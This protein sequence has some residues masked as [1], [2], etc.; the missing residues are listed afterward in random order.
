MEHETFGRIVAAL[1][2]EQIN[3]SNGHSWSQQDL[4]DETGLTQRIVSK[5]ERGRQARLDGG[6]LR[7]LARAFNLTSLERR[8]FFAMASEVAD[9]EIVRTDLCNEEVFAQVWALLDALCAPAFL[10]DPF[11]DVVGVNRALL[12]FHNISIA[13][14]QSF[15]TTAVGINNLALLLASDTPL[16]RVLGH[17]WR[18]IAL[19]NVQQ[20]RVATLRYRHT[21]RFQQLFAS[22]STY[23]DFRMLWAAGSDSEHVIEDCSRLRRCIYN[24]SVHGAVAYTVFTNVSLSAFGEIYLCSFVPQD[25]ATAV[26]FQELAGE[27]NHALPL[28]PWPNPGLASSLNEHS[29]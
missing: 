25:L 20:W 2:K 19:A 24:H 9:S 17:G 6:I 27:N 22:L 10:L 4:A 12:A 13:E 21:P 5:I 15:K 29:Q 11:A 26:L 14:L 16:R 7:E 8:E 28:T 1:R 3:L 18:P 23:P